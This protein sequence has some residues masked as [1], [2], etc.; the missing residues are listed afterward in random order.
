VTGLTNAILVN[1]CDPTDTLNATIPSTY[2]IA[3][4]MRYDDKCWSLQSFGGPGGPEL[5]ASFDGCVPCITQYPCCDCVEMNIGS[6][7]FTFA[8]SG[9]IFVDYTLCSG[10]SETVT[11]T[12]VTNL[13]NIC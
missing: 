8:D 11:A 7:L 13:F 1:C 9:N 3:Q 5:I 10:G 2:S 4:V 12:S 6:S